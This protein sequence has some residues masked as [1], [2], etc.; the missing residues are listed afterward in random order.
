MNDLIDRRGNKHGG[1]EEH[2]VG[3]VFGKARSEIAQCLAHMARNLYGVGSRRLVDA[4]GS[5][6]RGIETA[7]AVLRSG[8]RLYARDILDANNRAIRVG[9]QDNRG[10]LLRSCQASLGF[11]IDLYLLIGDYGCRTYPTERSLNVLILYC[12]ND[13]ARRQVELGQPV[14]IK[15][16]AQ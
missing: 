2:G 12:G 13:V 11:D 14:G 10:E 5:R 6:R 3:E 16:N 7:V 8:A 15:P 1:V 4:D 9:A